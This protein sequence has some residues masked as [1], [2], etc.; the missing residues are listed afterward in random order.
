[1][2]AEI[3][4]PKNKATTTNDVK[5]VQ[6]GNAN[7]Q[8]PLRIR[9]KF[10]TTSEDTHGRSTKVKTIWFCKDSGTG[11]RQRNI[12]FVLLHNF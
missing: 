4:S 6:N 2:K 10:V 1:M 5:S 12:D 3:K 9:E 7:K 8:I 11:R